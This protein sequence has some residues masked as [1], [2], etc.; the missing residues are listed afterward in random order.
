MKFKEPY[1]ATLLVEQLYK[2]LIFT[3]T[4]KILYGKLSAFGRLLIRKLRQIVAYLLNLW[5]SLKNTSFHK[6]SFK[7]F[8]NRRL[9]KNA[10]YYGYF[11]QVSSHHIV[12]CWFEYVVLTTS[13]FILGQNQIPT[14]AESECKEDELKSH[15]L[16]YHFSLNGVFS[17]AKII[18]KYFQY[19]QHT[20]H[21]PK[22]LVLNSKDT[23]CISLVIL[24]FLC[25]FGCYFLPYIKIKQNSVYDEHSFSLYVYFLFTF[26]PLM[27]PTHGNLP[28]IFLWLCT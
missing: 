22:L 26:P 4:N 25:Y 19:Q 10:V 1:F 16:L 11:S 13:F 18:T 15:F 2:S 17:I 20:H 14:T 21:R 9:A 6:Y 8:I 5:V 24:I 27:L 23:I 3:R 12:I 7:Y 28:I